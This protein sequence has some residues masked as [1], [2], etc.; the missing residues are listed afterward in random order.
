MG[1]FLGLIVGAIVM[2]YWDSIWYYLA[3]TWAS[4]RSR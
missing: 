3:Q 4:I 2:K 1:F